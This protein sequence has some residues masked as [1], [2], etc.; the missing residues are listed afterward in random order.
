MSNLVLFDTESNCVLNYPRL[1]E[2][3]VVGLDSRYTVLRVVREDRPEYESTTHYLRET[4]NVDLAAGEWRWAW[5]LIELPPPPPPKPDYVGFYRALLASQVYEAV[6]SLPA[7]A[8]LARAMVVFV[9]A[10][11]DCMAG[12]PEPQ[13][14]QNAIWLLLKQV[15]LEDTQT[16][17]LLILMTEYNMDLVYTLQP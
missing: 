13:S 3:P 12:R 7:T 10:I 2:A 11:Q 5:E 6:L 15:V 16:S 9:S 4:R 14:M 17:E 1:D 8:E